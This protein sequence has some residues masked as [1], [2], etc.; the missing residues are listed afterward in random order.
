MGCGSDPGVRGMMPNSLR[1]LCG[2]V[3][4]HTDSCSCW[5]NLPPFKANGW[6]IDAM[7][8]L[9]AF[10]KIPSRVTT[11]LEMYL[12]AGTTSTRYMK[13]LRDVVRRTNRDEQTAR[14]G[15]L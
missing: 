15:S 7:G 3:I 13:P 5:L 8:K 9:A 6:F 4:Q 12:K 2:L 1:P 10:L 11:Y 14:K